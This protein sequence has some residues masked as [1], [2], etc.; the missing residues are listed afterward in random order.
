ML[1]MDLMLEIMDSIWVIKLYQ[2]KYV[3]TLLL[4]VPVASAHREHDSLISQ[5]VSLRQSSYDAALDQ[6]FGFNSPAVTCTK[7][8][9]C[10]LFYTI[11]LCNRYRYFLLTTAGTSRDVYCKALIQMQIRVAM[12]LQHM[13]R[14]MQSLWLL[15][16]KTI[17]MCCVVY[18]NNSLLK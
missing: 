3:L 4:D 9:L 6:A 2:C 8:L 16:Y 1:L 10:I 11:L 5:H 15:L 14:R 13:H 18:C 12:L 7:I 17:E